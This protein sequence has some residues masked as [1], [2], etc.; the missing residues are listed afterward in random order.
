MSD[1]N[2]FDIGKRI[3]VVGTTGMGK[4]T[5]VSQIAEILEIKHVEMDFLFWQENWAQPKDEDFLPKVE[6]ALMGGSWVI[7]GNYTRA[8]GIIWKDIDSVIFLDYS[9]AVALLRVSFRSIKRIITREKIWGKNYESFK[10]AFFS[11]NSLIIWLI[12]TFYRRRKIYYEFMVSK[13]F[14]HIKF[15]KFNRP[16]QIKK[17]LKGLSEHQKA[18]EENN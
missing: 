17:W 12:T 4:T 1:Q 16:S 7:D 18:N 3:N 8:R 10:G 9:M 6:E 14:E 13:E 11:K 2:M 5:L 15:I